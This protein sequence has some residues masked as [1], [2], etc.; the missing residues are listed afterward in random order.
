MWSRYIH[1]VFVGIAALFLLMAAVN[2]VV[3][4]LWTFGTPFVAG[5][6]ANKPIFSRFVRLG[7]AYI[8]SRL[9]PQV[10]TLGSS[11]VELS[12]G[13]GH[14]P[15]AGLDWYNLALSGAS[16]YE[17]RRYLDHA[18]AQ[19]RLQE[20]LVG[21]DF[22]MFNTNLQPK[23][24]F[25]ESILA[26]NARAWDRV[27]LAFSSSLFKISVES[28][29]K[30]WR[31]S[32]YDPVSGHDFGKEDS[33]VGSGGQNAAFMRVLSRII[34]RLTK[35]S[36]SDPIQ[37]TAT[38]DQYE[39]MLEAAHAKGVRL[40]LFLSPVHAWF[41]QP[42]TESGQWDKIE[43]WK[44]GL[45]RLNEAVAQ[46]MGCAPF[47]LWDFSGYNSFTTESVPGPGD[48]TSRM[49]WYYEASHC[50]S[51][52]GDLMQDRMYGVNNPL[53]TDDFGL[54]LTSEN[55]EANLTRTRADQMDWEQLNLQ[56]LGEIR[57]LIIELKTKEAFSQEAPD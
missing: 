26:P 2:V 24:G 13:P 28:I 37:K 30:Q 8:V 11:R 1:N 40:K 54:R 16:L 55:I 50:R 23:P 46:R 36:G 56:P 57:Q 53:L 52:L 9:K 34:Q 12:I 10:V 43:D 25:D 38:W 29:G 7:K 18:I 42:Y 6:N 21:L 19:G 41:M 45:V 32:F 49:H 47:P 33:L 14:F 3:D 48:V 20:A 31:R 39:A 51:S 5:V 27:A 35:E 15:N 22:Y 4:P 17:M 44:R